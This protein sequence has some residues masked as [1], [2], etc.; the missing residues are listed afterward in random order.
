MKMMFLSLMRIG[1]SEGAVHR[2][3]PAGIF[4]WQ[5]IA[6]LALSM[7]SACGSRAQDPVWLSVQG[8]LANIGEER[9]A[10]IP[11]KQQQAEIRQAVA[12]QDVDFPLLMMTLPRRNAV[13]TLGLLQRYDGVEIWADA[14]GITITLQNGVVLQTRGLGH[15]ILASDI[16]GVLVG[17]REGGPHRYQRVTRVLSAEGVLRRQ[18]SDC[19]MSGKLTSKVEQ[20][21]GTERF[22]NRYSQSVLATSRQWLGPDLGYLMIER[23]Q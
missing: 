2:R 20:C 19:V 16:A 11:W 12:L 6:L 13:A 14:S 15:D 5:A 4:V 21:D 17:L 22:E 7:L 9:S 1:A 10:P 18:I 3:V 8:A 23:L